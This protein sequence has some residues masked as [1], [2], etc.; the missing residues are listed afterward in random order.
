MLRPHKFTKI[1]AECVARIDF[2]NSLLGA[3]GAGGRSTRGNLTGEPT[4][5]VRWVPQGAFSLT[6]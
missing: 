3:L 5:P 4:G 2:L 6:P 1:G